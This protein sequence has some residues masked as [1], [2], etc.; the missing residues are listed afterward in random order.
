MLELKLLSLTCS[1]L[2]S[3][4]GVNDVHFNPLLDVPIHIDIIGT[5][6]ELAIVYL[7]VM[8]RIFYIVM[9]FNLTKQCRP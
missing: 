2:Y 9:Y 6:M 1:L 8:S 4:K 7:G 5:C 3:V